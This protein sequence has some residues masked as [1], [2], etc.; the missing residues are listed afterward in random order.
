MKTI[1]IG[2]LVTVMDSGVDMA[3]V[4]VLD[5]E[6]YQKSHIPGA[7][8][9]PVDDENFEENFQKAV[10]D[11]TKMVVVYC[12]SKQCPK[13][14]KAAQKI[15]DLGYEEVLDYEEGKKGWKDAGFDLES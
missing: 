4:D 6:D 11:K 9:V 3:L 12:G 7:I 14:P 2:E 1:Q 8:N 15:D 10:P 5:K 13:S